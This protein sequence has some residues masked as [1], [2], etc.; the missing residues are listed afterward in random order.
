MNLINSRSV[1]LAATLLFSTFASASAQQVK[2]RQLIPAFDFATIQIPVEIVAIR[3]KGKEFAPGEKI[4]GDDEW[5]RGVCFTV[6]NISDKPIAYVAIGLRFE[7]P[8]GGARIVVFTLSYGVYYQ[9]GDP[10]S[11]S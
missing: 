10:R 5:L 8:P 7:P 3:L 4:K 2:D 11:G 6:K 1:F 9:G